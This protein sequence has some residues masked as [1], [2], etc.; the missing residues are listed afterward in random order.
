MKEFLS[1]HLGESGE[2]ILEWINHLRRRAVASTAHCRCVGG[3][4][5]DYGLDRSDAKR[6]LEAFNRAIKMA[7]NET[8]KSRVEKMSIAAYRA[9]LE[10]VWYIEHTSG[11][12]AWMMTATEADGSAASEQLVNEMKPVAKRFFALCE[13]Y[14]A[15]RVRE[16]DSITMKDVKKRVLGLLGSF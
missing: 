9:M 3:K 4:W 16:G 5:A 8:I 6:G 11:D 13:K 2:P 14:G 10:P 12:E 1:L 15:E 7:A